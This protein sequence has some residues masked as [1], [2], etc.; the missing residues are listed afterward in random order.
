MRYNTKLF[1]FHNNDFTCTYAWFF[2]L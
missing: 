2:F 1:F